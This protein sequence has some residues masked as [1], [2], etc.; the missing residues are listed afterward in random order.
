MPTGFCVFS[1]GI[2]ECPKGQRAEQPPG[3]G[4][5]EWVFGPPHTSSMAP[6]SRHLTRQI[7]RRRRKGGPGRARQEMDAA[8]AHAVQ[9]G[10]GMAQQGAQAPAMALGEASE[11]GTAW[12]RG[13][14]Q[15]GVEEGLKFWVWTAHAD[16][17]QRAASYSKWS[18]RSA[19]PSGAQGAGPR[20]GD[21]QERPGARTTAIEE[22][23]KRPTGPRR[24]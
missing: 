17:P 22:E 2:L 24:A 1:C 5:W 9:G 23:L 4:V 12:G 19:G 21:A 8:V 20:P 18:P 11:R 15:K 10:C 14:E 16:P 3:T 6:C 7:E 13:C